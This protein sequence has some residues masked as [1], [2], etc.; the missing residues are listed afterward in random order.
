[1]KYCL[2]TRGYAESIPR[3][4]EEGV[5]FYL[6]LRP[7]DLVHLT[8]S[9][10]VCRG[11]VADARLGLAF[12]RFSCFLGA[13][14]S[15]GHVRARWRTCCSHCAPWELL[16][17]SS[18]AA[19]PSHSVNGRCVAEEPWAYSVGC[20]SKGS[21]ADG[22]DAQPAGGPHR[23]RRMAAEYSVKVLRRSTVWQLQGT[24]AAD[25]VYRS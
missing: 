23:T 3:P 6:V 16:C 17:T 9:V 1:M 10:P 19:I 12:Y 22:V 20:S 21:G 2:E 4:S 25:N 14:H 7:L 5:S 18:N 13:L 11:A 8:I 24:T 15:K